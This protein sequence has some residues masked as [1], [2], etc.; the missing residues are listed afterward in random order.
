MADLDTTSKRR[1]SVG[2]LLIF[3]VVP[4]LSDATIDVG[5]RQHIAVSYSGISS[6]TPVAA[7]AGTR[8]M[9]QVKATHRKTRRR[10]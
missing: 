4:P 1:S 3:V 7:T 2:I 10:C 8:H 9:R 5:D 6:G